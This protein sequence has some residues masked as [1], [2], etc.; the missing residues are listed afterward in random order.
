[1]NNE[2]NE[3]ILN[4]C[5]QNIGRDFTEYDS[6]GCAD[7]V[8][9]ILKEVLGYEAGGGPSTYRM[10]ESLLTNK[11]FKKVTT[12][13]AE[14]GDIILS[15]TGYGNG[16]VSNGHVGFLGEDGIIYSNNSNTSK[17]DSH[18][19][20]SKWKSYYK[21]KGGFPVTYWRAVAKP[22]EERIPKVLQ[23]SK[24]PQKISLTVKGTVTAVVVYI[25]QYFG[26]TLSDID[27]NSIV[28]NIM[29]MVPVLV[30]IWGVVRK[31]I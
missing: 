23:S 8:N 16:A 5:K 30:T 10:Y 4:F 26:V 13:T 27:L 15:P 14:P 7:T 6:L 19:T 11:N 9:K 31:Y 17:L 18:L 21:T 2:N 1:M 28:D 24:D 12:L 29:L 3:K 25:A 20:A 22:V